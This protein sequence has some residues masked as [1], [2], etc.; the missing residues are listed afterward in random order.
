MRLSDEVKRLERELLD[1][2]KIIQ[3]GWVT[4]EAMAIPADAPPIQ[5]EE[6]RNAFFA[7]CQHLFQLLLASSSGAELRAIEIELSLFIADYRKR[8]NLPQETAH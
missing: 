2:N 7:G 6:M 1:A 3:A 8:H 5:R 4:F